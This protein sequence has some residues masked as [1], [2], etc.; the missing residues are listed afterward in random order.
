LHEADSFSACCTVSLLVVVLGCSMPQTLSLFKDALIMCL[1][2]GAQA[3]C[4]SWTWRR[5]G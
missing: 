2:A 5:T 3:T 4:S 1:Q